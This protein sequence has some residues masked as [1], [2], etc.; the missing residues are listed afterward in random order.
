MIK[1]FDYHFFKMNE[2]FKNLNLNQL[3]QQVP[4]AFAASSSKDG[5]N[6]ERTFTRS[7]SFVSKEGQ[8]RREIVEV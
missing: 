6:I 5:L 7:I 3:G 8:G 4:R 2:K 1:H